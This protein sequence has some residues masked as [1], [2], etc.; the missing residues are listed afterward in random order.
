MIRGRSQFF[1]ACAACGIEFFK[2]FRREQFT[3][4]LLKKFQSKLENIKS[5]STEATTSSATKTTAKDE[6][7]ELNSDT[8]LS[9]TLRFEEQGEVLAKDASTKKD[10]WYSN[11]VND[12]RNPINRRKRGEDD[13]RRDKNRSH[14][15]SSSSK[16]RR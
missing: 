16:H 2:C 3:L 11:D 5:T 14:G 13:R 1:L 10:D 7:E 12:P 15:T 9:H 8:W 4:Q 6:E